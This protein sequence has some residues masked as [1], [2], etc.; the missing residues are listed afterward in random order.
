MESH[1]RCV[2]EGGEDDSERMDG[3][4][5]APIS[6]GCS[7]ETSLRVPVSA[8]ADLA[9]AGGQRPTGSRHVVHGSAQC[10][11]VSKQ[12]RLHRYPGGARQSVRTP[13]RQAHLSVLNRPEARL[14]AVR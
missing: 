9:P 14:P 10:D 2:E 13:R 5:L 8:D 4:C 11:P 3:V 1:R 6:A 12:F 7:D